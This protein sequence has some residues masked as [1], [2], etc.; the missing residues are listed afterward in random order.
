MLRKF[1]ASNYQKIK[2]IKQQKLSDS[3]KKRGVHTKLR[4]QLLVNL[5]PDCDTLCADA[6]ILWK[7]AICTNK[8]WPSM[9]CV[10]PVVGL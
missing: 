9:C 6:Q 2:N 1:E 4:L 10:F 8:T 3:Y 7:T 5:K